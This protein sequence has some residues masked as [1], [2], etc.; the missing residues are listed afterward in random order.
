[1]IIVWGKVVAKAEHVG[2]VE[3]L[4]LGHVHRS[5]GEA[6]CIKHSVQR[7]VENANALVFYEE[8]QDMAAL[9]DHFQ[10]PESGKFVAALQELILGEPEIKIYDAKA[11]G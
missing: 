2:E 10:V 5:R 4:S 9:Q 11:A 6:G 1:V 3:R 8:W 7:D